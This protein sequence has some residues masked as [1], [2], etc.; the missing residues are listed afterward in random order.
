MKLICCNFKMNLL[1][2]DIS[3]YLNTINNKIEKE[4][5]I[6]FPS[7]PYI[8]EFS[9][10]GYLV[11]SQDISFVDF[12]SITGDT[13][14]N[15]LKELGI[16]YTIIGHSERRKFFDDDK[17]ISKKIKLAL[18]NNIK[19]VLCI[20]EFEKNIQ[21]ETNI[22]LKNEID[23]AFI[24]N[25]ELIN[26]NNLIIA[27][28][29]IWAIG[30]GVIPDN[31]NLYKTIFFIKSHIKK[32]YNLDLKVL[33]GG[34]VKLDNIDNLEELKIIDGYLIGGASLNPKDILTLQT[35]IK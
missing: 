21:E 15:Q 23:L 30:S 17:Y 27:Y 12:G 5:V 33:Y 16:T 26:N 8:E 28:E 3:N 10:N 4:K 31:K 13:S 25:K 18:N 7:I 9:K 6:F 32:T 34:S 24:D 29:P 20:G 2:K 19:V 11:G 35:K 1:K 22:F 14:I